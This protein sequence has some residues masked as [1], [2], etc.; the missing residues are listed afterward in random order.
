M[1]LVLSPRTPHAPEVL[2]ELL[3]ADTVLEALARAAPAVASSAPC[4]APQKC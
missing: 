4:T 3:T 1:Y 2:P